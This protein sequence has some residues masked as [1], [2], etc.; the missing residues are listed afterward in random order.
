MS[1]LGAVVK[2][3]GIKPHLGVGAARHPKRNP[4]ILRRRCKDLFMQGVPVATHH[5]PRVAFEN[6]NL[7]LHAHV[8]HLRR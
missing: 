2:D 4:A 6:A 3:V 1:M 8:P 7:A 5:V